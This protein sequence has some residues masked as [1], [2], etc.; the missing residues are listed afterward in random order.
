LTA[1]EIG[2]VV[3][4]LRGTIEG[5]RVRK[6]FQTDPHT[7]SLD[8][9]RTGFLV[10]SIHPKA[11]RIH[12]SSAIE[13]WG[14]TPPF[15]QLLR[16]H[17]NGR[18]ITGV[19]QLRG[20][21][22]VCLDFADGRN[23]L[24]AE[25]MGG[26]GNL[27]LL[28]EEGKVLGALRPRAGR[29]EAHVGAD[30]EPPPP[31]KPTSRSEKR[32]FDAARG[33]MSGQIDAHYRDVVDKLFIADRKRVLSQQLKRV[34]KKANRRIRQADSRL[35]SAK[36]RLEHKKWADLILANLSTI[37]RGDTVAAVE[38]LFADGSII[39]I[40]LDSKVGGAQNA[41]RYYH[42]HRRASR[43][44]ETEERRK[45]ELSALLA[46]VE[47]ELEEI[48]EMDLEAVEEACSRWVVPAKRKPQ[49]RAR[50]KRRASFREYESATGKTIL[51]G[52]SA[53]ENHDLTFHIA[54]G[55]DLW[56]HATEVAGPHVIVRLHKEEPIDQESLL[57]AATLA[58]HFS[59][60]THPVSGEVV[61]AARKHVRPVKGAVGKVTV[62]KPK[63]LFVRIEQGRLNRLLERHPP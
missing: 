57:D 19:E 5:C 62:A 43:T 37:K 52:R 47:T 35:A 26:Y 10:I 11:S 61:Y 33:S 18:V 49:P 59:A 58:V 25:L 50:Q 28:E 39:E 12:L 14:K 15:G 3:G 30:Y 48:D 27:W 38:D 7:V 55:R 20:D 32:R 63:K 51:V 45:A 24:I 41:E 9:G 29:R 46:R 53:S 36:G 54:R 13:K 17:L 60:L 40:P 42:S 1:T 16:K 4:E 44:V 8:L 56:L 34:S 31:P 22:V 6:V 23:R 2:L 21:R